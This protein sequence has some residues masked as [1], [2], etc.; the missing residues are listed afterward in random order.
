M[1]R[2]KT[3]EL[4]DLSR[5]VAAELLEDLP[6][7][8]AVTAGLCEGIRRLGASLPGGEY[9]EILPEVWV[10]ADAVV[11]PSAVVLGP[12]IVDHGA[13]IRPGAYLRGAVIIGK[14]AVVGNSTE[15]KSSLLFDGVQ[16]PHYNYVGD[17]VLGYRA[18]L[19]AGAVCSNVKSDK[20][21]VTVSLDGRKI[22]TGRRKFGAVVGDFGEVGCN[23]VLCPGTVIGRFATVYPLCRVRGYVPEKSILKESGNMAIKKSE[24]RKEF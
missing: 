22:P 1:Q 2:L 10:A 11:A 14:N 15:V 12:C 6:Y 13:V 17:S 8:W 18:H 5:T 4:L 20:S 9:R 21:P 19:G 7:P 3:K 23:S 24:E 16:V